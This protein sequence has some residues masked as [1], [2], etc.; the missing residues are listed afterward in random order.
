MVNKDFHSTQSATSFYQFC[1]Q[2]RYIV[3]LHVNI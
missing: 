1:L 2:L 3:A